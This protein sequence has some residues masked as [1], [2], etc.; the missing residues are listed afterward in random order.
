[1]I[2]AEMSH[3]LMLRLDDQ[4]GSLAEVISAISSSGINMIAICAYTLDK[5]V[6]IMFVTE[7]NNKA[8]KILEKYG[9][10]VAVEEVILL[11]IENKPGALQSITDKIADSGIDLKLIYGSVDPNDNVSRIVIIAEDNMEV[12]LILKTMLERG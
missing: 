8:K 3:Q 7:D 9:M 2:T 4:V 12:M 10:E 1:M 11:S 6:A 5:T